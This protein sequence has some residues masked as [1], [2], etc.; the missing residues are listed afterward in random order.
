MSVL[1]LSVFC[2][3]NTEPSIHHKKENLQKCVFEEEK[4]PQGSIIFLN[5]IQHLSEG[6]PEADLESC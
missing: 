1:A 2:L 6:F 5:R 3:H 4:N